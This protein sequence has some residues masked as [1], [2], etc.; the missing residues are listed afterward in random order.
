MKNMNVSVEVK[1]GL[2]QL[3]NSVEVENNKKQNANTTTDSLKSRFVYN[4]CGSDI[5]FKSRFVYDMCGYHLTPIPHKLQPK[6]EFAHPSPLFGL[7][8]VYKRLLSNYNPWLIMAKLTRLF[9][10]LF[11]QSIKHFNNVSLCLRNNMNISQSKST[12]TNDISTNGPYNDDNLQFINIE[13]ELY[14]NRLT[15]YT[16]NNMVLMNITKI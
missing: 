2:K 3:K 10:R 15:D 6:L 12:S 9:S 7:L 14:E 1:S 5:T 11:M 13:N 8:S 16:Y 4:A